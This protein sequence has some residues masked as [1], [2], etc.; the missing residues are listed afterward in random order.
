MFPFFKKEVKQTIFGLAMQGKMNWLKSGF[1]NII[2][3]LL[4]LK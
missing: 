4:N 2:L 1:K 3:D